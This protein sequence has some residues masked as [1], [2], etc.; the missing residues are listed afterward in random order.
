MIEL[1]ALWKKTGPKG[2]YLTGKLGNA[3]IMV[4]PNTKKTADNQPDFRI[5]VTES[6]EKQ[7]YPN[8]PKPNP[9]NFAPTK[10]PAS[11]FNAWDPTDPGPQKPDDFGF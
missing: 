5:M 8:R 10:P 4:F 7:S 9:Q 2:D 6:K 1:T 11:S 3:T